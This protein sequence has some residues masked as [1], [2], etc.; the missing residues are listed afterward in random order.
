MAGR[1]A[2]AMAIAEDTV[3]A[4]RRHANPWFVAYA[5]YGYGLAFVQ[6]DPTRA[7][8]AFR[9]GL[10]YTATHRVPLV[11]AII[12]IRLAGL[13]AVHGNREHALDLFD[14][15]LDSF[16]QAGNKPQLASRV[17]PPRGVLRPRRTARGR[18]HPLRRHHPPSRRHA[19]TV[20]ATSPPP[21]S[22]S[23]PCSATPS[24]TNTPPPAPA[25]EPGEIVAYAHHHI[26]TARTES[27]APS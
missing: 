11:Q 27:T 17:R 20:A 12:A 2:D 19:T 1:H 8:T 16:H 3:T 13:E 4:A 9:E 5:L 24:S 23:E 14:T 6:D 15:A 22:T 21:S 25:M 10:E 7:L 18:R 26:R